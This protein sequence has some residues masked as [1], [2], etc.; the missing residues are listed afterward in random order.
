MNFVIAN[1]VKLTENI[2]P[3]YRPVAEWMLRVYSC[4]FIACVISYDRIFKENNKFP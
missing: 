4:L 3:G 1:K 2:N